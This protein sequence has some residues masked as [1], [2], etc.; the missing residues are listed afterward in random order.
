MGAFQGAFRLEREPETGMDL[1]VRTRPRNVAFA[2]DD[3]DAAPETRLY[4]DELI[5]RVRAARS[6]K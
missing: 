5:A 6:G 3:A 4:A 1:A 2:N